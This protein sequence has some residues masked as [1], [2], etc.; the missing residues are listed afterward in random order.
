MDFV[1]GSEVLDSRCSSVTEIGAGCW[2]SIFVGLHFC[3]GLK[4]DVSVSYI[5]YRIIYTLM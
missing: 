4:I 2:F 5:E 3:A 1:D